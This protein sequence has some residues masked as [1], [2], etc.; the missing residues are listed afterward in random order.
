MS[1]ILITDILPLDNKRR[2]VYINGRYAFPL[3]LSELRKYH[4]QPNESLDDLKWNTIT[5]LIHRRIR[6][7]ILYLL[8]AM[9]RTEYNIRKKLADNHYSEAYV[10]PVIEELKSFGYIDDRAYALNFAQSMSANRGMSRKAIIQ[11]LYEKGVNREYI[12]E[13]VD[14]LPVDETELINKAL[15]KK[16]LSMNE[17]RELP[18]KEK[19]KIFRYLVGKGF[20]SFSI[21]MY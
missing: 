5:G 12:Y 20:S 10:N 2:K 17:V 15:K 11:K 9:P 4:I 6:E 1:N 13:A 18:P 16:G 21:N 14:T 7:R 3:Y 19:Q 8:E